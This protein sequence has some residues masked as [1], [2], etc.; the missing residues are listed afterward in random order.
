[1]FQNAPTQAEDSVTEGGGVLDNSYVLGMQGFIYTTS[2][3]CSSFVARH[4][5]VVLISV[6]GSLFDVNLT[7]GPPMR[8]N[9]AVVAPLVERQLMT[10]RGGVVSINV[11]PTHPLFRHFV[12]ASAPS[13]VTL[14]REQFT[15]WDD[16]LV[17]LHSG[18]MD[19]A[20]AQAVFE[21]L[22]HAV[23]ALLPAP[24]PR[25]AQLTPML[26]FLYAN[27]EASVDELATHLG[28]A[29]RRMTQ[30]F[31]SA[32]GMTFRD[33]KTWL[34]QRRVMEIFYSR[35]SLTSVAH[36]AGFTDSPQ[37]AR[38]FQR[39]FGQSPSFSRDPN[40]VRVRT[41]Q[42]SNLPPGASTPN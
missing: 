9:V 25:P 26:E 5:A 31:R 36:A 6:D 21:E 8:G 35:R 20:A 40:H 1:M 17:A 39:W 2:R 32:M 13:V 28:V 12:S 16:A 29:P 19:V 10:P 41:P 4:C 34:K 37:F 11:N 24:G 22:V 15:A 18:A 23:C 27:P 33:Y 7:K 38:A 3:T 42:A 14:Q 30:L